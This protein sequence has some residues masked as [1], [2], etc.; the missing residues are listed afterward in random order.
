M[1]SFYDSEKPKNH[2]VHNYSASW[3][4]ILFPKSFEFVSERS[5]EE[6]AQQ[7]RFTDG[8]G[9]GTFFPWRRKAHAYPRHSTLGEFKIIRERF[10]RRI[11]PYTSAKAVGVMEKDPQRGQTIV[12]GTAHLGGGILI[13]IGLIILFLFFTGMS[14]P[15]GE[16]FVGI[17]IVGLGI[18][19]AIMIDDR[20]QIIDS[21]A[22][23]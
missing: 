20:N 17:G 19:L 4:R 9:A 18:N 14:A 15:G 8:E 1:S 12:R 21:I 16:M 10:I 3:D 2:P 7:I 23:S 22:W 13:F 5:I 6:I 11:I